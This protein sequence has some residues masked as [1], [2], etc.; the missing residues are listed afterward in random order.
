MYNT[1]Q[2]ETLS[3]YLQ[4]HHDKLFTAEELCCQMEKYQISKSA[5][6]RNLAELEKQG[7]VQKATQNGSRKAYYQYLD[8]KACKNHIHLACTHC[9]KTQH[10]NCLDTQKIAESVKTNANF[11]VNNENTIIYGLCKNCKSKE[12]KNEK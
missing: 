7:K 5:V 6:Y 10:L 4:K 1:K 9:G 11:F 8:S 12:N 3:E 2:R